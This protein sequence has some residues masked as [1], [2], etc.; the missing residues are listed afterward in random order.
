METF[1]QEVKE[2]I[3]EAVTNQF[4]KMREEFEDEK[5]YAVAFE[6][7]S[8]CITLWLGVN[9]H[10]FLK[11]KDAKYGNE[12]YDPNTKWNPSEWGYS[13][14]DSQLARLSDELY[15]NKSSIYDQISK[16]NPNQTPDET[17]E[18]FVAL[19]EESRLTE[20]F[21]ETVTAAFQELIEANVFGF[22]HDEVTYFI[23]MSDDNRA[24]EIENNSAKKLNSKKIYEEF[25]NRYKGVN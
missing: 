15:E 12:G 7:D 14:G 6:T 13:D 10:E 5:P 23:T 20:L 1:F 25:L 22:N 18:Q 2:K 11:K 8:D 17:Y 16:Q 3:I 24:E 21:F 9:T 19:I 4:P